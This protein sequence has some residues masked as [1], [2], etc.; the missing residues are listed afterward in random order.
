MNINGIGNSSP[1][2]RIVNNPVRREVAADG[3]TT[4]TRPADK[5]EL[6][7]MSHLMRSLQKNDVRTDKVA[8]IKAIRATGMGIIRTG[9]GIIRT[10]KACAVGV[11][12]VQRIVAGA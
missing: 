8:Q 4:N 2:Q 7:G 11:S 3:T 12:V 5:L 10:A 6:S 9:M 1:V